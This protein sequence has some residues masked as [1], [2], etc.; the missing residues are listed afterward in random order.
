MRN[1][2]ISNLLVAF[3]SQGVS[4]LMSLLMSLLLPKLLGVQQYSYSQLFVFY[5]GYV[6][7]FHFGINDGVYLRLGGQD[8]NKIDYQGIGTELK[9]LFVFESILALILSGI[10]AYVFFDENRQFIFAVS[11]VYMVLNNVA[12]FLGY[13][14]QAVNETKWFS[15]SV[16]I[17]KIALI[18]F[19]VTL[20]L[21]KQNTYIPFIITY[22]LSKVIALSF[23][24]WKGRKIVFTRISDLKNSLKDMWNDANVGI[25]LTI[26]NIVSMLIIGIGRI[27]IDH[28]WGL[29]SFGKIS[30]SFS[31]TNF[32]L[33]FIQQVSMVLFP[34]LRKVGDS[35][36]KEIFMSLRSSLNIIAPFILVLY[37]PLQ[38]IL[39]MW[40]P[41]YRESLIYLAYLLPIC[42]FDGK[43]QMLFTT[44]FKV[45]RYEKKL[46][47]IN[48]ES[49]AVSLI[50]CVVCGYMFH[51]MTAVIIS[52]VAAIIFRSIF[53]DYT[54]S[55]IFDS[56]I[57]ADC[58]YELLL[59]LLYYF[60]VSIFT[61]LNAFVI[62]LGSY[63]IY[64]IINHK[65]V[66]ALK[67][68]FASR[69]L[70]SQ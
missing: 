6:G 26:S 53:S 68:S 23:C 3:L 47:I 38:S 18:V 8:F 35:Q 63:I 19:I 22:C 67:N 48:I 62:V 27:I 17:D 13:V 50:L 30:L 28:I 33:V 9:L 10:G 40:L 12:L 16:M 31:L 60:I 46:M 25:K 15:Y 54:L 21:L 61:P 34:S 45:L 2:F 41:S 51:N 5:V 65:E 58:V 4:L 39:S 55:K 29:E 49:F 32:F 56:K 44:Y 70:T 11:A 43:M 64:L 36:K 57:G 69:K 14:F 66:K 1:K 42:L 7:F 52:M 59:I 37:I 24:I 20:L